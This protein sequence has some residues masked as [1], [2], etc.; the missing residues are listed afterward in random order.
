MKTGAEII[1]QRAA[2]RE[3]RRQQIMSR[4]IK[5]MRT[6]V[7]SINAGAIGAERDAAIAASIAECG[8]FI[9][10]GFAE[11]ARGDAATDEDREDRIEDDDGDDGGNDHHASRV[12]DLLVEA[13]TFKNR[14]G[15]LAHL[16]HHKDGR[17]LLA[18]MHKGDNMA[19]DSWK[20][21]VKDYGVIAVAKMIAADNDTHGLDE[22]TLTQLATEHARKQYPSLSPDRA[23]A[24]LFESEEGIALRKACAVIK[25]LPMVDPYAVR[26][27]S[28]DEA[29]VHPGLETNKAIESLKEIGQ[30]RW[31]NES[32]AKQFAN[33]F[34][35]EP[36]LAAKAHRRPEPTTNYPFPR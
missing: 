31:P 11:L 27:F 21:I 24:K 16:L 7:E 25:A 36:E 14:Q 5:G 22:H 4:A 6:A 28:Q 9:G 3:Y 32:K 20:T 30:Q 23:F 26:T 18:R 12:A 35:A 34:A 17:A 1:A 19:K 13:G 29:E 15:A 33:A 8:E 10:K 2:D